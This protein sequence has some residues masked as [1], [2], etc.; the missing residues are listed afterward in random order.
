[1]H[2]GAP[3]LHKPKTPDLNI[4]PI[5]IKLVAGRTNAG[6]CRLIVDKILRRKMLRRFSFLRLVPGC[7]GKP[8]ISF[9][10]QNVSNLAVDLLFKQH[11]HVL[12]GMKAGIGR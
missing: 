2:L 5:A 4:A 8:R 6:L 11:L 7:C 1:V 3:K 9:P 10:E 12:F